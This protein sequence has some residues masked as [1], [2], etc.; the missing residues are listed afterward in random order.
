MIHA[1]MCKP[2]AFPWNSARV[3]EQIDR[4]QNITGDQTLNREKVYE[5][6][7]VG[8]LGFKKGVPSFAY[9]ATQ[10]EYGSM[11]F[12]YDLANK[13][14]PVI[15]AAVAWARTLT[16]VTITKTGHGLLNNDLITITVSSDIAALPL[17]TYTITY[18]GVDTF[19]V[20]GLNAGG[21]TGTCTYAKPYDVDLDDLVET[22][23][24]IA[25][26]LTDD[27]STFRGTIWFPGLRVNGFSINIA[28]PDATIERSFDLIGEDYKMLDE[29]Y[30]SYNSHIAT[31]ATEVVTLSP[32]AIEFASGDYVFKVLRVRADVVSELEEGSGANQ[33]SYA[34]GDVTINT[35]EVDDLI[36][37]YYPSTTAYTTTWTDN[38][39]DPDLLLAEYA[40]IRLKVGTGTRIYRLQSIGIDVAFDRADYKE[41]GNSEVVQRGVNNKTVTV[42]LNRFAEDFAL[43]D[44]LA[45]DTGFPYID[46]RNFAEDI[47]MQIK[48]YGEKAHTNFKM[49]Y[50]ITGLSP[51]TI[52]TTQDIESYNQR[53]ANLESDNCKIS[54]VETEIAF[55]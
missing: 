16:V 19:S 25:A 46:P 29:K 50:L 3:P 30:F 40:E 35:C 55:V 15:N 33:W 32:A 47:Q 34:T 17:G 18:I 6:G 31:V 23:C 44:I 2:R 53:T 5:I 27:D 54:S 21:A 11:S 1:K 9:S 14:T 12:W 26:F 28:D 45:S 41:I 51:T 37:I 52:G 43:E 20:V 38:N 24:D 4:L 8:R 7:R 22:Q 10:F 39:S 36:K 13:I 48:I 49:G 42:A